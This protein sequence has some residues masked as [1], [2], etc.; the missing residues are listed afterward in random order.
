[1]SHVRS[2]IYDFDEFEK[3]EFKIQLFFEKNFNKGK[4][5]PTP[6][7][8]AKDSKFLKRDKW[9]KIESLFKIIDKNHRIR[10]K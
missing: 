2:G 4:I 8:C 7:V 3:K 6:P 1:M 10:S 5:H 9:N